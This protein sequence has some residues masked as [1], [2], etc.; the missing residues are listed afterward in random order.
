MMTNWKTVKKSVGTYKSLLEILS[1]DERRSEHSKKEL[2]RMNRICEK[3]AKSLEGI[4]D[5]A[6]LPSV[7]FVIDVVNES[8]AISEARRLGIPVVG[9]VD[10]N[11]DPRGIDFIVPGNDDASRAI[12]LYCKCVADACIEGSAVHQ[13]KILEK[14]RDRPVSAEE[15]VAKVGG[16]RVVEITQPPRRGRGA[17][18]PGS[19][20]SGRTQSAG[21][22]SDGADPKKKD[23][24]AGAKPE[25]DKS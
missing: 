5:M 11:C 6:R 3:Y 2:A 25:E 16:R 7:V 23:E 15:K 13:E 21:G 19:T 4:K 8:I 20:G 14:E 17:G 18:G 1:D 24:G 12:D 10:T 22:W 9:I